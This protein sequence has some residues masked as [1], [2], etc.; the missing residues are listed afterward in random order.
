VLCKFLCVY[1]HIK[2]RGKFASSPPT[3]QTIMAFEVLA[4]VVMRNLSSGIQHRVVPES[5]P[6]FRSNIVSIFRAEE[7]AKQ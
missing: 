5:Q 7:E 2:N 1:F 4:A 3:A 6:T